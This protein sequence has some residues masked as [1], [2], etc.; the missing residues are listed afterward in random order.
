MSFPPRVTV[1]GGGFAGVEC[2][3][4][5]A[6]RGHGVRLVEM[7]PARRTDAHATDRLAEMVCS[8]SFRSDNPANA[9]GLLKREMEAVGSLV[10][11]EARKAAVP[12]GDALAVDRSVFAEGV[13]RRIADR[14]E[15]QLVRAEVASLDAVRED[16][17]Y[18]VVATGP[19]TSD[20][21][22]ASLKA[23]LGDGTLYFYDAVAP[24]VEASSI[25]RSRAFAASR[26]GKGSGDDYLNI[27]LSKAEYEAF[28]GELVR[29]EK[30][31]F[32][33]FE[34]A[35]YFEG[36]LPVEAM[37]ERGVETLR[38][39]PMKPFGLRDPRTG[40][41][42]YAAVQLRQDDLAREHWNLVGF[43]TKLKVGEQKRI[44]RALPGLE[45]ASFVRYGMLHRNTFLNGPAHLDRLFRWR[46][47]SSVFFAGQL[48]GVEG[49][50]ESAATGLM[51]GATLAQLLEGREPVPLP[52]T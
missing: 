7:R 4:Q 11:E 1:V 52:F 14:S 6:R 21:L 28:V 26:W 32:H 49:Y 27:P 47:D 45:N 51:V 31:A 22:A 50:L 46:K 29:G 8:N 30:V 33:D 40:K 41:E 20:A 42:P 15:I 44:F 19:L 23:A 43:Q 36:C 5:L 37:A 16:G 18:V 24:I 10:L 3:W 12:A 39:G 38:H 34:R 2:A 35:V 13:T 25:D 17:R 9:V 48:T